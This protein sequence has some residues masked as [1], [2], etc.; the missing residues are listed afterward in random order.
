L[1]DFDYMI[2]IIPK[3][4]T[5][6]PI[7]LLIACVAFIFGI[8]IGFAIALIKIYKIPVLRQIAGVYVSFM[9]GT[10]LLVQIFLAYYGIPLVLRYLEETYGLQTDISQ[11]P[12]IVFMYVSF[13]LNV[14]AY[15]S[16]S[17]R[18]ALLSVGR[19]QVEAAQS[20][21][22]TT[23]QILRRIII[24][25]AAVVAIPNLGNTFIALL[26]DTSL[27]FAASVPEIIG[28]AKITAARTSNFFEA[29]IAAALMYWVICIIF[30]QLLRFSEKRLRRHERGLQHD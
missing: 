7:S 29:Y 10:P 8:L 23:G 27:A 4:A 17:I 18:S 25:Q 1:L 15:L 24:P 12:A 22:M 6:V 2:G 14:G 16:E 26:K 21:G 11:I 3:V 30:E 5:G 28:Q 13:S 20:I 9:R 19:G